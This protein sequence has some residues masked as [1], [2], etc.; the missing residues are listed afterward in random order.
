MR[1]LVTGVTGQVGAALISRLSPYGTVIAADRTVMD[2]C[3]TREIGARLDALAPD[4]VINPA[5][6]T[7]V[8]RAE[9]DDRDLAFL[10]NERAPLAIARWAADN[11]VPFV[12]FSTDYVFDGTGTTP[13]KESDPPSPIC[14]YGASKLAGEVAIQ[15]VGGP[16]LI[17]RTS[18]V[19]TSSGTNFFQTIVHLAQERNEL[20]IVADQFGAPT[21]AAIIA[22][23]IAAMFAA[24]RGIA[25]IID[26][27]RGIVHLAA[28]GITTRYEFGCAI[29]EFLRAKG[30]PLKVMRVVPI[31]SD[32]YRMKAKR[33]LNCRLDLTRLA[34]TFGIS[35]SHWRI[36][37]EAAAVDVLC[38]HHPTCSDY[39]RELWTKEPDRFTLDLLQH[40][41]GD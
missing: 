35:M 28:S 19:Y 23:A 5:A 1:I 21:S 38:N 29:V 15:D 24:P 18:W 7:A 12:H 4:I 25:D 11:N 3:A 9:D 20:R 34:Q 33:P 14:V 40:K 8:D 32:A 31:G 30:L 16:H 17:V 39:I 27:C 6:Y 2:L 13:W 26:R 22:D 41:C 36:G 37:L 10:V